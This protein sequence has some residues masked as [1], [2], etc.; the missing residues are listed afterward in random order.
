MCFQVSKVRARREIASLLREWRKY[1]IRDIVVDKNTSRIWAKVARVNCKF[2]SY[3]LFFRKSHLIS[4]PALHIPPLSFAIELF[5]VLHLG[6]KANLSIARFTQE[7]GAK[8]SFEK[9]VAAV[10]GVLRARGLVIEDGRA[11]GMRAVLG[12]R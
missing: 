12:G 6:R 10:E 9:V 11:E 2:S 1:G 3:L 4:V 5:T 7:K 8:S